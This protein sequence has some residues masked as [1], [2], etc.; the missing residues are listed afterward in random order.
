MPGKLLPGNKFRVDKQMHGNELRGYCIPSLYPV[1]NCRGLL[2]SVP[3]PGNKLPGYYMPTLYPAMN[4][5]VIV[6]RPFTRQ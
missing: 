6:F 3:L 1:I 2:Y 4:Y 5:E